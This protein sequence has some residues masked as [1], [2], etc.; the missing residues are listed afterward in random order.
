VD[1]KCEITIVSDDGTVVVIGARPQT[2]VERLLEEGGVAALLV[3]VKAQCTTDKCCELIVKEI[4]A[5]TKQQKTMRLP[6]DTVKKAA[7]TQAKATTDAAKVDAAAMDRQT[8][9][10][11]AQTTMFMWLGIAS[12]WFWWC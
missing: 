9:A 1:P 2:E 11:E 10:I 5:Q 12:F 4:N 3:G 8:A 6:C 7:E